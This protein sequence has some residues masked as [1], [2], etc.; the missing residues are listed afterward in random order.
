MYFREVRGLQAWLEI[1][2]R[3]GNKDRRMRA[4]KVAESTSAFSLVSIRTFYSASIAVTSGQVAAL[5]SIKSN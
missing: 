1:T 3:A 4:S 2:H 5:E